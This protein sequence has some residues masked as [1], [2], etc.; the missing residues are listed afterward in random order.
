MKI[1]KVEINITKVEIKFLK[2]EM[3]ILKVERKI[4]KLCCFIYG[5]EKVL[6]LLRLVAQIA[7]VVIEKL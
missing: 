7:G 4:L 5:V 3:K 2:T 1:P 6:K